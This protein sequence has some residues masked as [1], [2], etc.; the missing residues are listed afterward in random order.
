MESKGDPM[1]DAEWKELD[2]ISV[3]KTQREKARYEE[4]MKKT[5]KV[6]EHP[7]YY[8]GPCYCHMCSTYN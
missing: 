7:E 1:T 6:D 3:P 2:F 4:L 8:D 5:E